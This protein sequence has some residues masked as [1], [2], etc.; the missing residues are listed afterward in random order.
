MK[1][2]I[3][4]LF[5]YIFIPFILGCLVGKLILITILNK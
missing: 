5:T 3:K 1:E 4:W 2:L